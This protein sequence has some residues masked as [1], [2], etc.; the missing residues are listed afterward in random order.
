ML[1][2]PWLT[3]LYSDREQSRLA[4]EFQSPEFR[5]DYQLRQIDPG[6]VLTRIRIPSVGVDALIVEGTD[7]R[8]LRAGAGHYSHT[9][10]PCESGNVGIAGHRNTYGEPF[11]RLDELRVGDVI[12][13][14]TPERSCTY[15][16]VDGPAG[17]RRPRSGAAGWITHP[18]D[19]AVIGP[20]EGEWLTL[21]TCHPKNSS[22][23]RLILRA[24]LVSSG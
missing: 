6:Q 15:E 16:V 4:E 9:P 18:A 24:Q 11:N 14:I 5:S 20:L 21:T 2:Y 19:G 10:L 17:T 12:E 8:A 22:A 1:S 3:D 7:P 13:L 23:E